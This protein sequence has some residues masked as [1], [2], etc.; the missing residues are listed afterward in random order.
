MTRARAKITAAMASF[1]MEP[2]GYVSSLRTVAIDDDWG[3][4]IARV[5]LDP[6]RFTADGPRSR[7][8]RRIAGAR[9][10]ALHKSSSRLA[11]RCASPPGRTSS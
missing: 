1:S 11:P 6:D 7:R 9:R 4:M 2:I 8:D 3:E 10:Q 5:S